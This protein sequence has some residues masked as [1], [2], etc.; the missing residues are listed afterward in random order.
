MFNDRI[1]SAGIFLLTE[2]FIL[3]YSY[4]LNIL[5]WNVPTGHYLRRGVAGLAKRDMMD[6][7]VPA[8]VIEPVAG[9]LLGPQCQQVR[10]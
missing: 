6:G 7:Q 2:Y 4:G 3:A 9:A 5:Y 10:L 8:G 1:F